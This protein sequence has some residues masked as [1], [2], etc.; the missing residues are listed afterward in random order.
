MCEDNPN[1]KKYRPL[2]RPASRATLPDLGWYY[3]EA[4]AMF[5][6]ANRP[7]LPTSRHR[8]GVISFERDLTAKECETFDLEELL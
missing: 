8:Y 7:D 5:G 1:T 6:L 4:P 2:L 3:V